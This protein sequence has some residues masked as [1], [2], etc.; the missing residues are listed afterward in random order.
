MIGRME[1]KQPNVRPMRP[2][3]NV[4]EARI[5]ELSVNSIKVMWGTHTKERMRERDITDVMLFDTL[6]T[7]TLRGD[8]IP[9]NKPGEWVA[10]MVKEQRGRRE[11]GVIT[12]V[13]RNERLFVKTVE[14]EDT[15]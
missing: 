15:K 4:L 3:P 10:K 9:G 11:V 6:R 13:I 1:R 12:V 7:G 5:R 2:R 14:W 8:I